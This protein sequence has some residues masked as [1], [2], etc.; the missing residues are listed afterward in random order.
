MVIKI[1][2]Q[3]VKDD[4]ITY[5][6]H[7]KKPIYGHCVAINSK[8]I[9]QAIQNHRWLHVSCPGA[10][11][12]VNPWEWLSKGQKIEKVY[13]IPN[14]PMV[15]YQKHVGETEPEARKPNNGEQLELV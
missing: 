4:G 15:L 2:G 13:R 1:Y 12:T 8:I 9:N 5:H 7:I 6:V 14:H 3:T 11:E 10:E